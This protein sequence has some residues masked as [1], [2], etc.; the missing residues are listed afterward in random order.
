M[1]L[2]RATLLVGSPRPRGTSTSEALGRY[3][4]RSLERAGVATEVR[5]VAALRGRIASELAPAVAPSDLLVLAFPLY[6]DALPAPLTAALE[7]LA[8]AR[9]AVAHRGATH[10]AAIVNCGFPEARHTRTALDICR[11]FADEAGF[12][13]AGGLGLGGG[14]AIHG[15][16]LER[17]GRIAVRVRR[18]LDL[19]AEALLAGRPV[20]EE[21]VALMAARH[22]PPRLYTTLGNLRWLR[23]A[24]R[25]GALRRLW[26]RPYVESATPAGE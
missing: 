9:V 26:D 17:A 22:V 10:L 23:D 19:A 6:V 2:R 5:F 1:T 18:A 3:M 7:G 12:A 24:G 13:W 14:E 16:P 15:A 21:A 20:P 11:A 8:A 25:S 4:F